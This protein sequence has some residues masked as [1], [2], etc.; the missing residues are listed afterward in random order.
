MTKSLYIAGPIFGIENAEQAFY[1][2]EDHLG[3]LGY[4][5]VN[6]LTIGNGDHSATLCW[7]RAYGKRTRYPEMRQ[8]TSLHTW[9]CY[10]K[11]DLAELLK[12]DGV[13]LL[14]GWESSSGAFLEFTVARTLNMPCAPVSEWACRA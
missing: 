1:D 5:I 7:I 6:P 3:N 14:P 10:M 13:A 2:A 8:D 4:T 9:E 11:Y 12:C